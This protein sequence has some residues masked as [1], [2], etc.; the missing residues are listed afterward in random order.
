[1]LTVEC[2]LV[3]EHVGEFL[4]IELSPAVE[5]EE[6]RTR[7]RLRRCNVGRVVVVGGIDVQQVVVALP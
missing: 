6:F 2:P 1:M 3:D 7:R 5:F 4:E